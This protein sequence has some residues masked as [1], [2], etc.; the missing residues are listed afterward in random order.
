[1]NHST[2]NLHP[3]EVYLICRVIV[4]LCKTP[5]IAYYTPI[6]HALEVREMANQSLYYFTIGGPVDDPQLTTFP[7]Y[8]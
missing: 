3:T 8:A 2:G 4:A 7:A 6:S 1:M 5:V